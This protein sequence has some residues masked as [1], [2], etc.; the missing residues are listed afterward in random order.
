MNRGNPSGNDKAERRKVFLYMNKV[1]TEFK[2]YV[3][4][5]SKSWNR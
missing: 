2:H 1:R 4:K 5:I 3:N